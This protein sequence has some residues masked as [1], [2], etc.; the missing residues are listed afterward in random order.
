MFNKLDLPDPEEPIIA[1]LEAFE[2][3]KFK[4]FNTSTL[5]FSLKKILINIF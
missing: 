2:M 5:F 4:F 1:I 3:L